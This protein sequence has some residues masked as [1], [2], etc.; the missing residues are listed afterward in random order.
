MLQLS[1][2]A[3]EGS[4]TKN[5][6]VRLPLKSLGGLL[7]TPKIQ[8]SENLAKDL[9]FKEIFE[10]LKFTDAKYKFCSIIKSIS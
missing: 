3:I 2:H 10:Y 6:L 7:R 8:D 5:N 1:N 9:G 4:T